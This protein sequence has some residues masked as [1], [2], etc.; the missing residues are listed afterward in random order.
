MDNSLIERREIVLYIDFSATL[1]DI[2]R[3]TKRRVLYSEPHGMFYFYEMKE[4]GN[5]LM[6]ATAFWNR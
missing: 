3:E 5:G 1:A 6:M 4:Y 2:E